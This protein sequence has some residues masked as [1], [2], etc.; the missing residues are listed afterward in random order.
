M[1]LEDKRTSSEKLTFSKGPRGGLAMSPS[2]K[3]VLAIGSS[4]EE[5]L[6]STVGLGSGNGIVLS[7][8]FGLIFKLTKMA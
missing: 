1:S 6:P 4:M 8:I 2:R 3:E 7:T 5:L